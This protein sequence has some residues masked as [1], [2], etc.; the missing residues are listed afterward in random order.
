MHK[1]R[2][3]SIVFATIIATQFAIARKTE[4]GKTPVM[5]EVTARGQ[6]LYECDEAAWRSTDA[7][8]ALNPPKEVL[9][10]YI[11][12]KSDLGWTVGFGHLNSSRDKFLVAYEATQEA[13][14]KEFA[15][16]KLDPPREDAS[17]YLFAARAID[18]ALKDFQGEKRP[19]NVAVLPAPS[20][21]LYVYV[22][23][24]QT[25]DGV[26]PLGG[27]VRYLISSDGNAIMEKRQLHKTILENRGKVPDGGTTLAGMH[28]HVLSDVPEDTD[29]FHVLTQKPPVAEY[30]R[31][32]KK[33]YI[34]TTDGTIYEGKL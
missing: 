5:P 4:V 32:S 29:V 6:M 14:G 34:I 22:T 1:R 9:G 20:N 7:V 2:L 28:T 16:K 11:P 30:V 21:Q 25:E 15:V 3:L 8:Q 27:D 13:R 17:F 31:T 33:L 26:Y 23:P 12:R 10:R 24:A 18:A 19:Y